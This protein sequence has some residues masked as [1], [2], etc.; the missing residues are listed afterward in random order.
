MKKTIREIYKAIEKNGYPWVGGDM[1]TDNGASCAIGQAAK[2]LGYSEAIRS[3]F[4]V[5][6]WKISD[7]IIDVTQPSG[8][9]VSV[10]EINDDIF[11]KKGT[12]TDVVAVLKEKLEPYFDVEVNLPD[13]PEGE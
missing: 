5:N 1:L 11:D 13:L 2:N 10:T 7:A 4:N 12:F 9:I 3:E 8:N 6:A